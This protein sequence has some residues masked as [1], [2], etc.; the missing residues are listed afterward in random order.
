MISLKIREGTHIKEI[1]T[2][3]ALT[4]KYKTNLLQQF[5]IHIM[6][7]AISFIMILTNKNNNFIITT[8]LIIIT[9]KKEDLC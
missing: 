4:M 7:E 8:S 2:S 6:T 5:H 9:K 1:L 3:W